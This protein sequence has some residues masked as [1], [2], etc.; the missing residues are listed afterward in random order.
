MIQSLMALNG[1]YL[2]AA[3]VIRESRRMVMALTAQRDMG[4]GKEALEAAEALQYV[5]LEGER[6][7][8]TEDF[9]KMCE[10]LRDNGPTTVP[11]RLIGP[12]MSFLNPS[13][14]SIS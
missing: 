13:F 12:K 8:T 7:W 3:E 1:A 10:A 14:P 9:V 6:L 11:G 5:N 4:K 2:T